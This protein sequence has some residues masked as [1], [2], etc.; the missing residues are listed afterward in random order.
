MNNF[1][2]MSS[3]YILQT[4]SCRFDFNIIF[5]SRAFQ[6]KLKYAIQNDLIRDVCVE[7]EDN[8]STSI[9]DETLLHVVQK[10][11]LW[12]FLRSQAIS[13]ASSLG[14][15]L[16]SPFYVNVPDVH[17]A[18]QE[19]LD[20]IP[21]QK[22][23]VMQGHMS[24]GVINEDVALI[25]FIHHTHKAVV[26]VG[27]IKVTMNYINKLRLKLNIL[28]Y[29]TYTNS[30][31]YLLISP[32]GLVFTPN[33]KPYEGSEV[34]LNKKPHTGL[35]EFPNLQLI[36]PLKPSSIMPDKSSI[37]GMLEIK[38]VSPFHHQETDDE[39]LIWADNFADRQ[40]TNSHQIPFV[41]LIQIA[42]QAI[43]GIKAFNFT[44]EHDIWLIRWSPNGFNLFHFQVKHLVR[45]GITA[46]LL[47]L[48]LKLRIHTSDDIPKVIPITDPILKHLEQDLYTYLDIAISHATV[49]FTP[50]NDYPE[51]D[52]YHSVTKFF[53][54]KVEMT[55]T[56]P[57]ELVIPLVQT[58]LP[59][60]LNECLLD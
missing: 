54:F 41:Y 4:A 32:D 22:T 6:S 19:K 30:T 25:H 59:K 18:W 57:N 49:T 42:L 7:T 13:T 58:S 27:C 23:L 3:D 16:V 21:F 28:N 53:K 15:Y 34:N 29:L 40:W 26:K 44:P 46:S 37:I 50:I 9:T 10:S 56:K 52:V 60:I 12:L 14:K 47:F 1:I 51:Y 5:N 48:N 35:D 31:D 24:A 33:K 20:H 17:K 39:F 8:I 43:A 2:I 38:C 11:Q 36:E 55:D 45:V